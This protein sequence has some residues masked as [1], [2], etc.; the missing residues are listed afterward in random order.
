MLLHLD[1][2]KIARCFRRSLPTYDEAAR[3]QKELA[4]RLLQC[5][6][7]L[8]DATFRRVLEIG[9]CTGVLT[10]MLCCDKPVETLFL[11]DL[12]PEFEKV[13]LN[14]LPRRQS[15]H[16]TPLFG[17]IETLALPPDINLVISGATFQWLADLPAFF[18]RLGRELTSGSYLAFSLFGPGTLQEFSQ[19]TSVG[20][21]YRSDKEVCL[22]LEEDFVMEEQVSFQDKLFFP[23]VREILYHIR[24]TGVGGVSEYRWSRE[25]LASFEKRYRQEFGDKKGLPVSYSCSCFL[26]RRR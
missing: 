17:D 11:N 15:L 8:P 7:A 24:A 6:E 4:V 22:L 16:V 3:V 12:V 20:L 14:K 18:S 21:G 5:L 13:T 23:S 1:K 9:C 19:L 26:A 2:E 25:T 10:E